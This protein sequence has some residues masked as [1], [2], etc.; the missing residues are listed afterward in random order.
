MCPQELDRSPWPDVATALAKAQRRVLESMLRWRPALHLASEGRH[1]ESACWIAWSWRSV[2]EILDD[3]SRPVLAIHAPMPLSA[4]RIASVCSLETLVELGL[5]DNLRVRDHHL[6]HLRGLAGLRILDLANT[7]VSDEAMSFVGELQWLHRLDLSGCEA[8]TDRALAAVAQLAHLRELYL[9]RVPVTDSGLDHLR[10]LA[11]LSRLDF[12][13]SK[14]LT[15]DGLVSLGRSL[16]NLRMSLCQDLYRSWAATPLWDVLGWMH[17]WLQ[18]EDIETRATASTVS[19]ALLDARG[20]T[21]RAV[22]SIAPLLTMAIENGEPKCR[23]KALRALRYIRG[24][25]SLNPLLPAAAGCLDGEETVREAALVALR[26]AALQGCDLGLL[27]GR[28]ADNPQRKRLLALARVQEEGG[29][30]ALTALGA[31]RSDPRTGRDM[32]DALL[33]LEEGLVHDDESIRSQARESILRAVKR[34]PGDEAMQ[35]LL[36]IVVGALGWKDRSVRRQAAS[37]TGRALG[38]GWLPD[39]LVV[40][41][42]I[43]MLEDESPEVA[44]AAAAALRHAAHQGVDLAPVRARLEM[45]LALPRKWVIE[46]ASE[47]LSF[48]LARSGEEP[49]LPRNCSHRPIYARTAEAV[50]CDRR[51]RCLACGSQSTRCIHSD[52]VGSNAGCHYWW[53]YLCEECGKYSVEEHETG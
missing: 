21:E 17:M 15:P 18:S 19:A 39:P 16:P 35:L 24:A 48:H 53:E 31:L 45:S 47:A 11:A 41:R 28:H 36:P 44:W 7:R 20:D 46:P 14:T 4:K 50:A 42:L 51:F 32:A 5:R 13:R 12:D 8:L 52:A 37:L 10:S 3:G 40:L 6:A 1:S 9:R 29:A 23:E 27:R 33:L 30:R 25:E 34:G 2:R 38:Q 26:H 43:E 22:P 49:E